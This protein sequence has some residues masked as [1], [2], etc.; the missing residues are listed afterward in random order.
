[1]KG[2]A[3]PLAF[4]RRLVVLRYVV[5]TQQQIPRAALREARGGAAAAPLTGPSGAS[6]NVRPIASAMVAGADTP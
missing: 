6:S 2:F 1:V 3:H 5:R 4:D